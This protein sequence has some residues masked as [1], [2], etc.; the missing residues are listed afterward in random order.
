MLCLRVVVHPEDGA[1]RAGAVLSNAVAISGAEFMLLAR[2][3]G[4]LEKTRA[5]GMTPHFSVTYDL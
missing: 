4:P 2:S 1:C 5:F 3:L